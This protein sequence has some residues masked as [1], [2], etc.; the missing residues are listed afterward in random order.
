MTPPKEGR[1]VPASFALPW[2]VTRTMADAWGV[3][4]AK[5]LGMSPRIEPP[6]SRPTRWKMGDVVALNRK[7]MAGANHEG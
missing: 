6:R 7:R 1:A 4:K 3:S 5:C 2:N